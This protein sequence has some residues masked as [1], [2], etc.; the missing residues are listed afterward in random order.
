M[1][2]ATTNHR[3][4]RWTRDDF[5]GYQVLQRVTRIFGVTVWIAEIDR[6][7][8]PS[9]AS[10]QRATLGSTDWESRLLSQYAALL[11]EE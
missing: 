5:S 11:T 1:K 10:I 9:W 8:V 2:F 3:V 6:E 7:D 4:L